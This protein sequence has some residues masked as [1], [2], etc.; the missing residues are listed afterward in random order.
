[1]CNHCN[2]SPP[3][4]PNIHPPP[5]S[6]LCSAP[7]GPT[8]PPRAW[9]LPPAVGP[10]TQARSATPRVSR[11]RLVV[12]RGS[13]AL[14]GPSL[15]AP[16]CALWGS[17]AL[18]LLQRAVTAARVVLA[19][20]RASLPATAAGRACR[21]TPVPQAAQAPRLSCAPVDGSLLARLALA[22]LVSPGD[23]VLPPPCPPL[24]AVGRAMRDGIFDC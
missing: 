21:A 15:P 20:P 23:T 12:A 9:P 3:L 6:W 11:H 10:V 24:H 5:C 7:Q 19:T 13:R 1:L 14:L 8:A 16:L 2:V 17:S 18:Q 4:H 22:A